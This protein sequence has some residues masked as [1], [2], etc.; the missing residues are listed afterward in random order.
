MFVSSGLAMNPCAIST[1]A[2]TSSIST[3]NVG[4]RNP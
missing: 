3:E 4:E 1:R 2:R